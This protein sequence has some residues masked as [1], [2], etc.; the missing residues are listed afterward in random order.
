VE[1]HLVLFGIDRDVFYEIPPSVII[2]K[3]NFEFDN[4]K[5]SWHALKTI[6][7]IRK[8]IKKINPNTILSYGEYW[9]SLVL[10]AL[11]GKKY[12]IFVSDRCQ[13]DKSLGK[14]HDFLRKCFYKYAKG[15]IAQT[16]KAKSIYEA[17]FVNNLN[18]KVI[19]NPIAQQELVT[20]PR[21]KIV[22]SVGRLI[23]TKHHNELIKLF[24]KLNKQDWK[25]IIVGGDALR[26]NNSETLN[27]LIT[28]LNAQNR[29]TL[30][31]N[32]K[33]VASYYTK[34]AIFAFTSSSEGFPNVVGEALSFG[35]PVVAFDC[36]AGPSDMIQEGKNGNLIKLF[37]YEQFAKKLGLLMDDQALR[38]KMAEFA[39]IS[40][41][42]FDKNKI[43][44][45]Y[46]E[47]IAY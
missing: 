15:I 16:S 27:E 22:L 37:D 5:R 46:Y 3:P 14:L 34:S 26:Q 42:K 2:H 23:E 40:I 47:F 28:S 39:P 7:F 13:P 1:I 19:G 41:R 36:I 35:L 25:L 21:E 11:V 43:G 6:Y 30:A 44:E 45:E 9:N 31:G 33:D 20:T 18:I 32:Q 24:V 10:L 17:G 38:S 8:T 29:V 4:T 12:P